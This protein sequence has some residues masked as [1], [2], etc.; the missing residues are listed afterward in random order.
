MSPNLRILT[1][2]NYF[3]KSEFGPGLFE[4]HNPKVTLTTTKFFWIGLD[5]RG[6]AMHLGVA[7]IINH[8]N[9]LPNAKMS[10]QSET[11]KN[12]SG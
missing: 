5:L 9:H 12:T 2:T 1:F 6:R 4:C 11:K 3:S 8:S 10:G 7:K